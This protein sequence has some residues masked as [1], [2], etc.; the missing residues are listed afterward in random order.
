M[1]DLGFSS[2]DGDAMSSVCG[3]EEEMPF[4][5]GVVVVVVD[6]VVVDGRGGMRC[7]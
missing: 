4:R 7:P 2:S 1:G 6:V 5:M 3:L